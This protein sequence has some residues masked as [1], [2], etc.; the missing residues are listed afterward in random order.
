MDGQQRI[1]SLYAIRKGIRISKDGKEIDFKDLFIDLNYD[2]E[3]DDQIVLTEQQDGK[4]YVSVHDVLRKPLGTFYKTLSHDQ[5]DRVEVVQEQA[6]Q[7]RLLQQSQLRT[8]RSKSLAR[9]S[10]ELTPEAKS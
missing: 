4:L 3:K 5:A 7:L 9:Y 6:D 8:I 2:A 1:T 10:R